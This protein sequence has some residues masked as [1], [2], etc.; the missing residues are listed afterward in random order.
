MVSAPCL[1]PYHPPKKPRFLISCIL[2]CMTR[3]VL[4]D[5]GWRSRGCVGKSPTLWGEKVR[6]DPL[7]PFSAP[8]LVSA[9]VS[10]GR[11]TLCLIYRTMVH[12]FVTMMDV[13]VSTSRRRIGEFNLQK[14]WTPSHQSPE[15]K[16][17]KQNAS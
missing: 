16:Q 1:K 10:E 11:E 6:K 2:W 15:L 17:N 3:V 7:T 14:Y 12:C 9:I 13:G 8:N 5:A 4:T